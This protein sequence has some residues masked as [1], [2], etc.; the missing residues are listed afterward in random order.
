ME[1]RFCKLMGYFV[2]RIPFIEIQW[3]SFRIF[4]KCKTFVY[5]NLEIDEMGKKV[6]LETKKWK[7]LDSCRNLMFPE[8]LSELSN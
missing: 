6:E 1:Q 4:R 5:Q 3:R 2:T 7:N 8:N